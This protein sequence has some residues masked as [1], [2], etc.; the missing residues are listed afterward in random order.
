MI[1]ETISSEYV[2]DELNQNAKK[3]MEQLSA[4]VHAVAELAKKSAVA[5]QLPTL[6]NPPKAIRVI[7]SMSQEALRAKENRLGLPDGLE[8]AAA[9]EASK[10][11]SAPNGPSISA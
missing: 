4:D 5:H 11:L 6:A 8:Q 2:L 1:S 3:T 7:G 9:T 10:N